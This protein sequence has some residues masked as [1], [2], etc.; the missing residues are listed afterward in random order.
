MVYQLTGP[1]T[2]EGKDLAIQKEVRANY[3]EYFARA[4]ESR[5]WFPHRLQERVE[6]QRLSSFAGLL[7]QNV[8]KILLGFLA[9]ESFVDDYVYA[10]IQGAGNDTI[11][12]QMTYQWGIEERRHGQTFRYILIDS[13]LMTQVEVD[14]FLEE[15]ARDTWAFERQTGNPAT[16]VNV[17]AYT[18]TQ[19]RQTRHAY[20]SFREYLKE[21]FQKTL[22]PLLLVIEKMV[23]YIEIDEGAHEA[24]FRSLLRI[25]FR[26]RPLSAIDSMVLAY[27]S[28]T[29]PILDYPNKEEFQAAIMSTGVFALTKWGRE[30]LRP[31]LKGMG[32]EDRKAIGVAER[33]VRQL[34]DNAVVQIQVKPLAFVPEGAVVYEM[35]P[36][37][38][39]SLVA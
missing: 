12:K 24:N 19:E 15:C 39:F 33:N 26:Y 34:P 13:G 22:N 32:F 30:I 17:T 3:E 4:V 2:E 6:L 36:Q 28:Y 20:T 27:K 9:V 7:D 18:I 31:A 25:I 14:Q 8:K 10:G 21:E 35:S 11:V 38:V 5:S 1:W 16:L 29:M 37:G 23:R